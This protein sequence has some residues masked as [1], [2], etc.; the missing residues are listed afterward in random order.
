MKKEV[1][2]CYEISSKNLRE[3]IKKSLLSPA[4]LQGMRFIINVDLG[5]PSD[6][7]DS[8]LLWTQI[9]REET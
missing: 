4:N 5:E 1:I 7:I 3:I 6:I 2:N 8:L 9:I